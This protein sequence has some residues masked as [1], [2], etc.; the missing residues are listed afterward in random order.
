MIK[1]KAKCSFFFF[2]RNVKEGESVQIDRDVYDDWVK[3]GLCFP[4]KNIT[5]AE[6]DD[7]EIDDS[8]DEKPKSKSKSKSKTKKV[9]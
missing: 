5:K 8:E 6:I 4:L 9:K 2:G 1:V 3:D 7:A